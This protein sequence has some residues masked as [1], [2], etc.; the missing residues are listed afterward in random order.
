M[1]ENANRMVDK[2]VWLINY[3]AKMLSKYLK[4]TREDAIRRC[5]AALETPR[6]SHISLD[7]EKSVEK[8][9]IVD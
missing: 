2:V 7:A 1:R 3:I 8:N 6:I 5:R 4:I 9:V